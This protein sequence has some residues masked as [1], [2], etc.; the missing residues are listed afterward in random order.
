MAGRLSSLFA[1]RPRP[2]DTPQPPAD[3]EAPP[4]ARSSPPRRRASPS[5]QRERRE[6]LRQ[7]EIEIRDLGGLALEM[8]RRD[9]WRYELLASRCAEALGIEERIQELDSMLAAAEVAARGLGATPCRCGAPILRGAHFCSHC[10][11]PAGDVPPVVTCRR[12]GHALPAEANFCS[13]CGNA[14]AADEFNEPF[15]NTGVIPVP[16]EERSGGGQ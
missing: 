8:A 7:R 11:R 3:G 1:R 16:P 15:E 2:A 12:C 14:A 10:G 9:D 5:F 6:L 13:F 4:P